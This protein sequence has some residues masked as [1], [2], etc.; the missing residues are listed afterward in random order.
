MVMGTTGNQVGGAVVSDSGAERQPIPVPENV[1]S[2]LKAKLD[3]AKQTQEMFSGAKAQYHAFAEGVAASIGV[4]PGYQLDA[5]AMQFVPSP[6]PEPENP[7]T[8]SE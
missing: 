6:E 2:V 7:D 8:A 4:P 3:F 5:D 1:R